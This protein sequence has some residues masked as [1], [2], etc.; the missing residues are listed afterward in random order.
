MGS[1]VLACDSYIYILPCLIL[2]VIVKV[3]RNSIAKKCVIL[4]FVN[5][6]LSYLS[7][8]GYLTNI[9]IIFFQIIIII[10]IL[11]F[12]FYSYALFIIIDLVLFILFHILLL[13]LVKIAT[14][15]SLNLKI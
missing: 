5:P 2:K 9:I 6:D 11:L 7:T 1:R 10:F 15:K 14:L 3:I 4:Y 8:I 13:L 12:L